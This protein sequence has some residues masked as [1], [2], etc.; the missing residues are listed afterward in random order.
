[1]AN[2]RDRSE[3]M[4]QKPHLVP[5]TRP[6]LQWH[7]LRLRVWSGSSTGC[8]KNHADTD[9][10][11]VRAGAGAVPQLV[12]ERDVIFGGGCPP[13]AAADAI[14]A[15]IMIAGVVDV[16]MAGTGGGVAVHQGS[17]VAQPHAIAAGKLVAQHCVVR[18]ED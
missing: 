17:H 18:C 13:F 2:A 9:L 16:I 8:N 6:L 1:M 3:G 7:N 5:T 4:K 15:D 11:A 14:V 10:Q 12:Q